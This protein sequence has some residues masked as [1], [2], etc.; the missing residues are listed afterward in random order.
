MPA[1]SLELNLPRYE[2]GVPP[3]NT[4]RATLELSGR[5]E[6]PTPDY[7]TGIFP[8][9]LQEHNLVEPPGFEPGPFPYNGNEEKVAVCILSRI[10]VYNCATITPRPH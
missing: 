9:K 4:S 7:K 8:A 3:T 10:A 6:L 5:F 2:G 1:F